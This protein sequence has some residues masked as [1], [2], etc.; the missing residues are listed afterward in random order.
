MNTNKNN[1]HFISFICIE[2]IIIVV[3][4]VPVI[5]I[6]LLG[7]QDPIMKLGNF[8]INHDG[9]PQIFFEKHN[10]TNQEIVKSGPI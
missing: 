10:F 3:M 7:Q 6:T 8:D 2:K 9:L 5:I 4:L 1:I